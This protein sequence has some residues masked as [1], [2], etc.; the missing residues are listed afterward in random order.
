MKSVLPC[1]PIT[2]SYLKAQW[3]RSF[4]VNRGLTG[5]ELFIPF[6]WFFV[7]QKHHWTS[8][9]LRTT[10]PIQH[11]VFAISKDITSVEWGPNSLFPLTKR[12]RKNHLESPW[13][14]YAVQVRFPLLWTIFCMQCMLKADITAV[15]TEHL[16]CTPVE[17][18]VAFLSVCPFV[19]SK[20]LSF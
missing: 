12:E 3:E 4:S 17:Q 19:D 20:C 7:F 13:I 8:Q 5:R 15:I 10:C 18:V 14:V 6:S 11:C 9:S 2:Q 16:K 1:S